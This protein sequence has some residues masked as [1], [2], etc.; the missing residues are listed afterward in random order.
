[1]VVEGSEKYCPVC[2]EDVDSSEFRRF[3]EAC[4]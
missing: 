2:G 1:M 4:C 3:G